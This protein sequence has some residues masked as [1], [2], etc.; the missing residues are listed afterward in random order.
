MMIPTFPFIRPDPAVNLDRSSTACRALPRI[1]MPLIPEAFLEV[2]PKFILCASQR[3]L[4]A[5]RR[6][7]Q[8]EEHQNGDGQGWTDVLLVWYLALL[9]LVYSIE[10]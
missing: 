8:V 3:Q 2:A 7:S 6:I 1:S 9:E 4:A 10:G 5:I